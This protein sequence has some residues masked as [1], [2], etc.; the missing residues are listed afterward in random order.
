MLARVSPHNARQL[1]D[2]LTPRNTVLA[3]KL[4][5]HFARVT[6]IDADAA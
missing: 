1:Q 3:G 5:P 6:G 4:A 2:G